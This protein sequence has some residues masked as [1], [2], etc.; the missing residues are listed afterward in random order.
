MYIGSD[1]TRSFFYLPDFM[2]APDTIA[3]SFVDRYAQFL[4]LS[5]EAGVGTIPTFIVGHMSGE[6]WDVSWRGGRDVYADG[7]VLAQQAFFVREMASRFRDHPAVVGWLVSNEMPS[8]MSLR[9]SSDSPMAA[10]RKYVMRPM[11]RSPAAGESEAQKWS[12]VMKAQ[13]LT[14]SRQRTRSSGG[15]SSRMSAG[16]EWRKVDAGLGC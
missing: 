2:P 1:V 9:E 16:V 7:W 5:H 11:A 12:S 15:I 3:E 4:D 6:N 8:A 13:S 10:S 14:R